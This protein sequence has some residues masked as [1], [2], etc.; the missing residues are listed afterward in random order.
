MWLLEQPEFQVGNN[1]APSN[2]LH[3]PLIPARLALLGTGYNADPS[4][5]GRQQNSYSFEH[6]SLSLPV[7]VTLWCT[8]GRLL[9]WLLSWNEDDND[10]L[11]FLLH[12]TM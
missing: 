8:H 5:R 6:P 11:T 3:Q 10:N 1:L 9:S 2:T 4:G 7:I 12:Y